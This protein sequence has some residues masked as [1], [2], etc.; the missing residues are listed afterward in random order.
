MQELFDYWMNN[1]TVN[2]NGEIEISLIKTI[3]NWDLS[4][5]TTS[6]QGA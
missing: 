3:E 2:D 1:C 6:K 5:L 4:I